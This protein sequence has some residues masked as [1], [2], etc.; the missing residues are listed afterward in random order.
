LENS[1]KLWETFSTTLKEQGK[2]PDKRTAPLGAFPTLSSGGFF[3]LRDDEKI[4][5]KSC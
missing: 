2:W 3:S 4:Y 1:Q 5:E